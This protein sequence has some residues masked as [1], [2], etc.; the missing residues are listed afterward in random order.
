MAEHIENLENS[1][2]QDTVVPT[3]SKR[4]RK[5]QT[6]QS[7]DIISDLNVTNSDPEPAPVDTNSAVSITHPEVPVLQSMLKSGVVYKNP[8]GIRLYKSCVATHPDY[9]YMGKIAIWSD[10]CINHRVRITDA[11]IHAGIHSKLLGW[12]NIEELGGE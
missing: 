9:R 8:D 10:D 7:T 11:S 1:V 12:V 4:G 5:R 6:E 3:K 2:E